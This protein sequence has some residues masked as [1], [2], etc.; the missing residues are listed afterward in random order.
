MGVYYPEVVE[1]REFIE[2]VIRTEEERFH[3][4]LSDGLALLADLAAGA[5]SAGEQQISGQDAFKLYDTFGFPF[6]LT[7]DYASEQGM[8]VDREGF[9]AAMEEQRIRARAARQD[10]GSMNVQGGPLADFTTKSDFIGYNDLIIE[11]AS[12]LAIVEGDTLVETCS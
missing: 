11:G 8:T 10:T 3:E 12:I 5:R 7:E 2:K 6:D 4:T 9:D 1:K